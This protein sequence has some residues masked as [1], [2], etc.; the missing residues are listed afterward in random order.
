ML[1]H[2]VI[3]GTNFARGY[4]Y[5][6][7]LNDHMKYWVWT[8]G[9]VP[10]GEGAYA[11]NK[12]LPSVNH[13]MGKR[14]FC[15]GVGNLFRRA[16]GEKVPT[17]GDPRYDGGVAAYWYTPAFG[18][19][20]PGFFSRVDVPFHLPTAK[21]WA[22]ESGSGVLVGRI[23]RNNTLSGQGHVAIVLPDGKVLQ[24]FQFGSDGEPGLNAH[25]TIE[26]SHDGG[27]Y[28]V[29]VHPRDWINN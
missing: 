2:G 21:K 18:G 24:S 14:I 12:P 13:L 16:A 23:Y 9:P 7:H 28:E 22:A 26:Q 11:V 29:M 8:S 15:A 3:D 5:I 1:T 10:D 6:M 17:R 20:G 25:Y 19:L 27:Y 4:K